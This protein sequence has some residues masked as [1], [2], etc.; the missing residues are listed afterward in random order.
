MLAGVEDSGALLNLMG[1]RGGLSNRSFSD[2][3]DCLISHECR[4]TTRKDAKPAGWP[5]GR[6]K[7]GTVSAAIVRVLTEAGGDLRTKDIQAGVE[8][9]LEGP[10]SRFSVADYLRVRSK[11]STPLFERTRRGY[12]RLLP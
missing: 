9:L 8:A 3:F 2:L 5:D 12:Y 4:K 11:G 10:V 7:F 6:R 1:L